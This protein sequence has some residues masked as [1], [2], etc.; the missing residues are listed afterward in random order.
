MK[1]CIKCNIQKPFS[2]FN[3]NSRQ[4]DGHYYYCRQ[5]TKSVKKAEYLR[6]KD[7]YL[8][9]C[10]KFRASEKGKLTIK[11]VYDNTRINRPKVYKARATVNRAITQGVLKRHPCEECGNTRTQAHHPNYNYPLKVNWLC[12]VCHTKWHKYNVA[13]Y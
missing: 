13:I 3:K 1:K 11:M 7:S 4:K 12:S 2:D 10:K 5:C 8:R 9:R 6:N